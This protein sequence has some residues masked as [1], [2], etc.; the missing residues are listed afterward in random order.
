M[1]MVTNALSMCGEGSIYT[2]CQL[3]GVWAFYLGQASCLKAC[4]ASGVQ[5][6][7]FF[8]T[9]FFKVLK[10]GKDF[11][12]DLDRNLFRPAN[13]PLRLLTSLIVHGD[14]S[15]NTASIFFGHDF[16]PSGPIIYPRNIPSTAPN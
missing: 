10:S 9:H 11:S 16:L 8:F 4:S 7:S 15:C 13:F 3:V 5:R 2:Q 6:K 1:Q 14:G 12:A